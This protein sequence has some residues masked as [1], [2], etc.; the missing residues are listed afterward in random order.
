MKTPEELASEYATKPDI[1]HML[2]PP[3][4]NSIFYHAFL[5]GYK[6]AQ[7]HAHHALEE[8]EAKHEEFAANAERNFKAMEAKIDQLA[9]VSKKVDHI[10]HAEKKVDEWIS[11]KDRLPEITVRISKGVLILDQYGEIS[12][13][14]FEMLNDQI[15][16]DWGEAGTRSLSE[17]THWMPLPEAPKD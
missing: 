1:Q 15:V 12:V 17:F 14:P 2:N 10:P 13:K 8:A 4:S 5:A 11:V 6:A 9:D 7:E 3:R 16:V